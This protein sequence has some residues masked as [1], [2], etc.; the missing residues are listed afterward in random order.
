MKEEVNNF[1]VSYF[2]N[3]EEEIL[4]DLDKNK[5]LVFDPK[6]EIFCWSECNIIPKRYVSRIDIKKNDEL[7]SRHNVRISKENINQKISIILDKKIGQKKFKE[8]KSEIKTDIETNLLS[9]KDLVVDYSGILNVHQKGKYYFLLNITG[10]SEILMD[11]KEIFNDLDNP[12]E[13]NKKIFLLS[14]DKGNH[15]IDIHFWTNNESLPNLLWKLNDSFKIISEE[16]LLYL[17][18]H[19]NK[20]E[21]Y[22][23]IKQNFIVSSIPE[24]YNPD[25]SVYPSYWLNNL[26]SSD[27]RK[28]ILMV[29][30]LKGGYPYW[31]NIT[32]QLNS[33]FDVWEFYYLPADS[34]NFLNSGLLKLGIN[35]VLSNYNLSELDIVSHSMG[36]LISLGYIHNMGKSKSKL[37]IDY[38]NNIR[39][40]ITIGSPLQGSYLSN[41]IITLKPTTPNIFCYIGGWLTHR[42]PTDIDAQSYLDLAVGS[43]YT[44]ILNKINLNKN[45]GYLNLA[46]N[47]GITCVFDETRENDNNEPDNTNDGIVAISSSNLLN[48]NIPLI[49]LDDYDHANE[50]GEIAATKSPFDTQLEV[51]IITSFLNGDNTSTIKS[52][53]G[54]N[55]HYIDPNNSP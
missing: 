28:P 50:I 18:G 4:K 47:K 26:S 51:N 6:K 34:S 11:G 32:F 21:K 30:G 33:T 40:L 20:K 24:S 1:S 45:I 29:H 36:G 8:K 7:L 48:Q 15:S 25:Y 13:I 43:E 55:D 3:S 41:K 12:Q 42:L 16:N 37:D 54:P 5:K 9:N 27:N 2:L 35:E 46:G 53:L 44:W 17:K 19:I 23:K 22:K 38:S 10:G 39:K 49:V 31:N 14:L 52:Q